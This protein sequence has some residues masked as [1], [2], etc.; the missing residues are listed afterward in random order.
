MTMQ[1]SKT[2]LAKPPSSV[3]SDW[4]CIEYTYG[5]VSFVSL[6]GGIGVWAQSLQGARS[7]IIENI[8]HCVMLESSNVG[9]HRVMMCFHAGSLP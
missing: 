7:F 1:F 5:C 2:H 8:L 3:L 6:Q 9:E 4:N